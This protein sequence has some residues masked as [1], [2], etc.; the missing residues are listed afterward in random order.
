ME[1]LMRDLLLPRTWHLSYEVLTWVQNFIL[2]LNFKNVYDESNCQNVAQRLQ[3]FPKFKIEDWLCLLL[4]ENRDHFKFKMLISYRLVWVYMNK[5]PNTLPEESETV[6]IIII[7][8][9]G[10]LTYTEICWYS[11]LLLGNEHVE[12]CKDFWHGVCLL[13]YALIK[14]FL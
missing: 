5:I 14:Y 10:E 6:I 11:L 13:E 12:M 7:C 8:L 2:N 3:F 4:H 9:Q 1:L